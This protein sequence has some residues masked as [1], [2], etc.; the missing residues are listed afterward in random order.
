MKSRLGLL[1]NPYVPATP[2]VGT[3]AHLATMAGVARRSITVLRNH[4]LPV[5]TGQKVLVTGWGASTT[6]NLTAALTARGLTTT[7]FYTG[8]PSAAV[9]A[10][11]VAA[12]A[13]ADVT[14]VTTS[15]VYADPTQVSLVGAL[16][17]TGRP[18]IV[19]AVNGPY[20][21]ASFPSAPSYVLSYDYQPVSLDALADVLTGRARATGRLPVT[22]RSAD[23]STVLF[24][25]GS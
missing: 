9:I 15:T 7:R 3:A 14:V 17:A 4:Y 8:S 19:A 1:R 24:P 11:A 21:I 5:Q 10:Q 20:D 6:T 23:G 16:L 2:V 12:S 22:I 13:A 18:V 25:Y